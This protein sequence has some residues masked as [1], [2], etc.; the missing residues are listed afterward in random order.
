M[1]DVIAQA[2]ALLEARLRELD[3]EATR[4]R[5]VLAGL[6]DI[7]TDNPRRPSRSPRRRQGAKR[8]RRGERQQQ[9][10]RVI[11]NHPTAKPS[12]IA[13]E[14]GVSASQVHALAR[15]LQDEGVLTKR[16][17]RYKA[18]EKAS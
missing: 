8:A 16:G 11:E 6:G 1:A 2:R 17:L 12:E 5:Q 15:R 10:L 13:K 18:T 14:M 4:L 7:A 9:F 3:G